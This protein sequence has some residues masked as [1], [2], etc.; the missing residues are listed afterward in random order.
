MIDEL[1][2][3]GKYMEDEAWQ[4]LED[5]INEII[6]AVNSAHNE[7]ASISASL[8][9]LYRPGNNIVESLSKL[10][11]KIASIDSKLKNN[12]LPRP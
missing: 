10:D 9:D 2:I 8:E 7:I 5:K 4:I 1:E 12:I 11:E 6:I 3:C